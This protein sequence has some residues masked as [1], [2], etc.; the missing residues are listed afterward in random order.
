MSCERELL[1]IDGDQCLYEKYALLYM[2][3]ASYDILDLVC[4]LHGVFTVLSGCSLT[5]LAIL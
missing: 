1:I 5:K 4:Y 2:E 3:C